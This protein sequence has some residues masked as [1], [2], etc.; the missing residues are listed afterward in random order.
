MPVSAQALFDWHERPGAFDRLTPAW[1]PVEVRHREGGI[2]DG[3]RV[4]IALSM[5]PVSIPWTLGHTGYTAVRGS[6]TSR[7]VDRSGRGSMSTAWSR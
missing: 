2:R 6:V 5:G 7:S 1:M 4:T 3:A